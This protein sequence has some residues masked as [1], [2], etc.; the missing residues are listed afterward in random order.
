LGSTLVSLLFS[1]LLHVVALYANPLPTSRTL[2]PEYTRGHGPH[3]KDNSM[4]TSRTPDRPQN[5]P[6][7]IIRYECRGK[8]NRLEK[9]RA[10]SRSTHIQTAHK[11][12]CRITK[13]RDQQKFMYN[14]DPNYVW[15]LWH[16]VNYVPFPQTY[17][18]LEPS[19]CT[20]PLAS[21]ALNFQAIYQCSSIGKL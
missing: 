19:V 4:Q 6:I 11:C 15:N 1:S 8:P 13:S 18:S 5:S 3:Y 17:T 14:Y 7:R 10:V 9:L 12:G 16:R 21:N 2:S 20:A